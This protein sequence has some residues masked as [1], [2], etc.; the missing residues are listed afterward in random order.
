[1]EI[2]ADYVIR[3]TILFDNKCGFVL[4]EKPQGPEPLCDMANSTSRT[5]TGT[6]FGATT[7]TSRVWPSVTCTTGP[8]TINGA[9]M[10]RRWSRAPDKETYKYYSTQRPIDI[11]TYPKSYFK[12][13]DPHGYLLY[14]P[15][16]APARRFK[17]GG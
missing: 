2:N 1:M 14:P 5:D 4:G 13:P 10:C 12:P 3:R 7:T 9:I 15:A 11:G 6:T 17:H 8:R 16:G